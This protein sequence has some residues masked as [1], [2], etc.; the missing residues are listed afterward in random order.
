MDKPFAIDF[1]WL[2]RPS[3][4]GPERYT[5]AALTI[6]IGDQILTELEDISSRTVR[7]S[8]RCSAYDLAVWFLQNWW[9]IVF[10]PE[11]NSLDWKMSHCLGGI[12]QG[13]L[14]PDICFT[15]DGL[16][17][18]VESHPTSRT[19][20]EM[21]RYL[22]NING[23]LPV[24]TFT[25]EVFSFADAVI[26]RLQETG[27]R[28]SLLHDLRE[29]LLE[30]LSDPQLTRWREIEALLGFDPEFA[31][32]KLVKEVLTLSEAQGIAAINEL[33]A[34]VGPEIKPLMTWLDTKAHDTTTSVTIPDTDI[35]REK[36]AL[37]DRTLL[38]WERA[39]K[40]ARI[41]KQHWSLNEIPLSNSNLTDLFSMQKNALTAS[42]PETPISIG[43]RNGHIDRIDAT[44]SCS[45]YE[46][47]RRFS[48]LR[49]V[50]DQLYSPNAD[51]L[52]PVTKTKTARQKFQRAFAQAFLC[53][54][55]QLIDFI[56]NDFSDEKIDDAAGYFNVS[57][58]LVKSTLVNKGLLYRVDR[59]ISRY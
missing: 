27:F 18:S 30:E 52:L 10:E 5:F 16:E 3:A 43:F 31:P 34:F 39:E 36:T 12:G 48:L 59:S 41:A 6:S 56:G 20:K 17:M 2:D 8:M 46:T 42:W 13:F 54:A 35:L 25:T 32:E 38:P 28:S 22:N 55:D 9:R 24:D 14:W 21:V 49:V 26:D 1:E 37:I 40:A 53:P 7:S 50:A 19:N 51:R 11:R 29:D 4:E 47:N 23:V 57:P 15:S 33:L 58:L 45:P 44:L